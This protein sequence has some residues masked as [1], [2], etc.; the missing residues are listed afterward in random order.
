MRATFPPSHTFSLTCAYIEQKSP[1]QGEYVE[2]Q[3][4]SHT[5][6]LSISNISGSLS[7]AFFNDEQEA[8]GTS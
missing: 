4:T 7:L 3:L 8:T 6:V 5:L 2:K 1:L